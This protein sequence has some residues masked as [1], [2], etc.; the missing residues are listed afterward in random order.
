MADY[1]LPHTIPQE[2]ER[3]TLMSRMLDP[4][5]FFRVEQVGIAPGWRCLEVG[6]GNGSVSHWLADRVGPTG[7]VVCSDIDTRFLEG[8]AGPNLEV[9]QDRCDRR[10]AR[11][12]LRP[13]PGSRAAAPHPAA[14][15]CA[16]PARRSLCD[17]AVRSSSKSPT[18][19]RCLPRTARACATSGRASSRGLRRGDRLL[20][21]APHRPSTR[22]HPASRASRRTERRS[23]S[24]AARSRRAISR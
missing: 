9:R 24:R 20:R 13:G 17:P 6:A 1:V 14:R 16:S 5:L 10:P 18:S 23:S 4:Q 19:T 3:L 12:W 8:L 7:N 21:R 11:R 22:G 2:D 15:R